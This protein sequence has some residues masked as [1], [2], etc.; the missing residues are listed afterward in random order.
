MK[1][2]KVSKIFSGSIYFENG[3]I[4]RS[5]HDSDCCES[6]YLS[7][8]D[9]TMD[10]FE[11]LEFNLEGEDFFRRI[12]GYGIE[13]VPIRG[14]SVRIPGYGYNNGYYSSNLS[15]V[16]IDSNKSEKVFDITS[17]QTIID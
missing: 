5:N 16:L 4:L 2:V 10:D 12:D 3:A 14:H 13:L 11:E 6:H 17:C 1:N 15:L 7:M 9:L 8:E